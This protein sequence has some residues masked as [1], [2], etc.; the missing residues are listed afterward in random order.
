MLKGVLTILV[1][2][3][4]SQSSVVGQD[5]DALLKAVD[6]VEAN[7]K[8]M[9]DKEVTARQQESEKLRTEMKQ[10]QQAPG[11]ESDNPVLA[12]MAQEMQT[13]KA[14][15]ARLSSQTSKP[16]VSEADLAGIVSDIAALKA[17]LT[18]LRAS[19]DKNQ[20]LLASL[21]DEGFYVP[22]QQDTVL[23]RIY[24]RLGA[25]NKQLEGA[26]LKGG[27]D[28][29]AARIDHGKIAVT[30]FVHSHFVDPSN[31]K[32][33]FR[34]RRAELGVTGEVNK[35]ARIKVVS[36]FA[37]TPALNDAELTISPN[38]SWSWSLGQYKTP[39]GTD[40][41][42][43]S[44]SMPFVNSAQ[45][46]ALG[47]S[48][49]VGTSLS[50]RQK[51]NKAFSLKLTTGF[52]NGSGVNTTDANSRK[53]FVFRGEFQLFNMFTLA[54][55]VLTGKNNSA[56]SV[57]QDMTLYGASL[58]WKW[59]S[60]QVL[61]EFI[62]NRTGELDKAGWYAWASQGMNTGWQFLPTVEFLTRYEQMDPNRAHTD[63]V[64][65]R[66]TLGANLYVDS[67][68][69]KLQLN[70]DLDDEGETLGQKTT[71]SVNLQVAF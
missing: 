44:T 20:K 13:L 56:D 41:L 25:I 8:A 46:A 14:E 5:F 42:T 47:P 53:N 37:G 66:L 54:P 2:L 52:F 17:E 39:F 11:V 24:E 62:Y 31:E 34:T 15:V 68:Y 6:Q 1:L 65:S 21:D 3:A 33:T 9:V 45:A 63:D 67:K 43:S 30:A 10:M 38:S 26:A 4:V 70:C 58:G 55:N 22:Q 7:L 64:T 69:T 16:S 51:F 71:T 49:D 60:T 48:R 23:N 29:N 12:Q 61:A 19:N 59:A 57:A 27:S 32:S 36:Q 50:F 40:F 18:A 28:V 35:Y